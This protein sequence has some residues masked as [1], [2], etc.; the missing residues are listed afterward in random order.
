VGAVTDK[1]VLAGVMANSLTPLKNYE[2]PK[3]SPSK[4]PI[5]EKIYIAGSL[6]EKEKEKEKRI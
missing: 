1:G 6:I 5:I 4:V 3:R 2:K